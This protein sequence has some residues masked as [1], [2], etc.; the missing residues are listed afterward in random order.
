MLAFNARQFCAVLLSG[1]I[2]TAGCAQPQTLTILHTNDIHAAFVPHEATW[3]KQSPKPMVGGFKELEF[4]VDSIR[5][6]KKN[7][8]LLD[9]GD[10]MTG[11]PITDR[12]YRGV[13][14]GA[15]FEMMNLVRYDAW[16]IGN[17]DFDISQKN[18][19]G[20]TK[21]AKFPSLSANI[22]NRKNE[23]PVNN[24]DYVIVE[25]A[26]LRIGIF[27]LMS[28][29]LYGL[30]N[31]NNLVGTFSLLRLLDEFGCHSLVFSSSL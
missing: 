3:S 4:A 17:H 8:L 11:N 12:I 20:L 9:G 2:V 21:I 14:G 1:L 26:G 19:V 7:V 22:V 5:K 6:T 27:G 10:V 16:C 30:V 29:G 18:L 13:E 15:L 28:Q 25:R 24:K 31:Q 23:F